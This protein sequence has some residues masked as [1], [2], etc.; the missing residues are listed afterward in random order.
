MRT[1]V[2]QSDTASS[3]YLLDRGEASLRNQ[4]H[5]RVNIDMALRV[6]TTVLWLCALGWVWMFGI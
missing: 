6:L 4:M 3:D 2:I 5:R 1:Q